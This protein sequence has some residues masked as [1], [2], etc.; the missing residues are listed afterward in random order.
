MNSKTLLFLAGGLGILVLII[1]LIAVA[2]GGIDDEVT[3][4]ARTQRTAIENRIGTMDKQ[5]AYVEGISK[6][7]G[8]VLE[9]LTSQW[10]EE[11]K[12]AKASQQACV[13]KMDEIKKLVDNNDGDDEPKVKTLISEVSSTF[14]AAANDVTSIHQRATRISEFMKNKDK[15]ISNAVMKANG[16]SQTITNLDAKVIQAGAD[17]PAKKSDLEGR[18][19]TLKSY[20]TKLAE[21]AKS[22]KTDAKPM[23]LILWCEEIDDLRNR[24]TSNNISSL[25]SQLYNSWDKVLVDMDIREV[26][27]GVEYYHTYKICRIKVVPGGKSTASEDSKTEKVNESKFVKNEKN[28]GMTIESKPTGKYDHE[29]DRVVQPPMYNRIAPR[30]QRNHYGRWEGDSWHWNEFIM[31][32]MVGNMLSGPSIRYDD[33]DRYHDNWRNRR[34]YYGRTTTGQ[35][36]YGSS[37]TTT[38]RTLGNAYKKSST[39]SQRRTQT[40]QKQKTRLSQH[41]AAQQRAAAAK[42]RAKSSSSR[43]FGGK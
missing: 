35:P 39:I 19:R 3:K 5:I 23:Q 24:I 32:A 6:E 33:Y 14:N 31:G 1:A 16:A 34:T 8:E 38:R 37:G 17:W 26:G 41:H 20:S 42:A 9:G 13:K 40:V 4:R 30:G 21:L 29:V 36:K 12:K 18:L 28:L 2:L 27:F 11:I 43:S 10:A 22:V 15:V 7:H 25:V